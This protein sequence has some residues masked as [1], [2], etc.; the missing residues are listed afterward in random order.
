MRLVD[1]VKMRQRGSYRWL[2][3]RFIALLGVLIGVG[4]SS[5]GSEL[6]AQPIELALKSSRSEGVEGTSSREAKIAAIRAI[7]FDQL[8][9]DASQRLRAIA[10]DASYFR[11]MPTQT[12]ECD[13]EMYTFLVRHPEVVVNI[14]DVMGITRV[15]LDRIGEYQ[16]SGDD[17]A[18]TKCKMDLVYGSDTLHVYQSNGGYQGN[19]WARELKGR[20]VA[21]LHNRP[22]KLAD[23]RPGMMAWMDA[24]MKLDNVGAD[25]VVKTLGPLVAKTADHN[26]VE[27]AGFFSQIS[28]T[29]RTNPQG[30]EQV[31]QQLHN[32]SPKVREQFIKTSVAVAL[33]ASKNVSSNL[34]AG[35]LDV[36]STRRLAQAKGDL[37]SPVADAKERE[38][39][40]SQ[41]DSPTLRLIHEDNS[42]DLPGMPK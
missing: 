41:D 34:P 33:R 12:V 22:V 8:T 40:E 31:A 4:L 24:F 18:G 3:C 6:R 5:G 26:F 32:V 35:S 42:S 37:G 16:L 1:S 38:T 19:L 20:C 2:G 13:P 23:G 11:R 21:V 7:P 27:C 10:E 36:S 29:A 39:F 30:L 9:P 28:Q 17:G 15:T 14:W 25:L